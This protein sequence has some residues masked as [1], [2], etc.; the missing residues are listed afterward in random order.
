M[1]EMRSH[2]QGLAFFRPL[3]L[4]FEFAHLQLDIP[5]EFNQ[6]FGSVRFGS[7]PGC[8]SYR[9]GL[10]ISFYTEHGSARDRSDRA[11][12]GGSPR[13]GQQGRI[14]QLQFRRVPGHAL[15]PQGTPLLQQLLHPR[16]RGFHF[17][18]RQ[19]TLRGNFN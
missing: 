14:L 16:L 5:I 13:I 19:I 11:A 3:I 12:G 4:P 17:R 7:C 9:L 10:T 8:L 6:M 1:E 2:H 15:R 18:V